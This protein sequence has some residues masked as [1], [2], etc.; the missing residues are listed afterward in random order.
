MAS[1]GAKVRE[2]TAEL[3][4][5]SRQ[6]MAEGVLTLD[7]A[8]PQDNDLPGWEPGAHIDLMLDEEMTRQY[9]LCG[10]PRDDEVWRVGVLLDPESRGGSRHVHEQ[11]SEGARVRVR[12]PRNHFSLVDSPKYLFI[13]GGIGITPIRPMIQ[14]ADR[15]GSDW[16]LVYLGRTA[17]TMAFAEEL[18]DSYGDHV[19]LWPRDDKGSFD[20]A[21]LLSEPDDQT[22]IYCCGPERL[23]AAAEEHC[24]NWPSG[25]LHIERFS[26]K[27][28]DADAHSEALESFSVVCQRSGVTIEVSGDT[29]ILE[30]LEDNDIEI[31]SSCLEG[32]CG[33]CEAE[34]VEGTPDHRDSVLSDKDYEAGD[35]IITCVSRSRTEK[36]VLDV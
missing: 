6:E 22:A 27:P 18:A 7:L 20:L 24:K 1:G 13:A 32:T 14:T 35:V 8:D 25:S 17:A 21:E 12:G 16:T 34:V 36:L 19:R 28:V 31:L 23:L 9:S 3:E 5:R 30:A 11:L 10:D 26:A 33:T 2:F 15:S 29:T 4:V